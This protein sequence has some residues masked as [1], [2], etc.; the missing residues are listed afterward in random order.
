MKFY[1]CAH[2]YGSKVL[3]RG[4]HNGVRFT[5]RAEFKPTLYVPTNEQTEHTSLFGQPLAPIQFED[6]NARSEE[7]TSELQSH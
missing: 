1:T 6:N 7:H 3:V 5:K 2:Q 4:V